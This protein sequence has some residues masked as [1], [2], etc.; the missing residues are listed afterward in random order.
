MSKGGKVEETLVEKI[1]TEPFARKMGIR[2]V[3]VEKGYAVVEMMAD[4]SLSNARGRVHRGAIFSL[5]DE[6]GAAASNSHGTTA[7]GLN[8]NVIYMAP[9]RLGGFLRA[10]AREVHRGSR[11][12]TY[13]IRATDS[14]GS[15][16]A[17]CRAIAY[18]KNPG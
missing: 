16:I 7:V 11:V 14:E 17:V 13:D 10:E 6:A 9:A 15:L 12:A 18:L 1:S 5:L 3:H 2:L 4:K 8:T